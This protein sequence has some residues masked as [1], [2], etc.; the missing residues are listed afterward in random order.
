MAFADEPGKGHLNCES[1][2]VKLI[3][4]VRG[5]YLLDPV[6]RASPSSLY[7]WRKRAVF[8]QP[9]TLTAISTVL[10]EIQS[11]TYHQCFSITSGFKITICQPNHQV[12]WLT[13]W[14]V[15]F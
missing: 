8:K 7:P 15:V 2:I 3:V 9:I 4:S 14:P 11:A 1:I 10:Y 5:S 12:K 6:G 13:I